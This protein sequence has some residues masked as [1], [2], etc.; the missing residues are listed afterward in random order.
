[1]AQVGWFM[2][3]TL[4][5]PHQVEFVAA[6]ARA[7]EAGIG[8]DVDA[9]R[10][11]TVPADDGR[12]LQVGLEVPGLTCDRRIL[13]VEYEPVGVE[14]LPSLNSFWTAG[15]APKTEL[16]DYDAPSGLAGEMWVSGVEA[17]PT[18]CAQWAVAWWSRQLRRPV[19]RQEWDEPKSAWRSDPAYRERQRVA[20]RWR[21]ED[22]DQSLDDRGTFRWWWLV[23]RP[24][25]RVVRERH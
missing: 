18:E 14:G 6:L 12:S 5:D 3:P 7:C 16:D 10:T 4:Q 23:R 11:S 22:P 17:T 13:A 20:A 19:I 8:A 24:P 21:L 2:G 1:M 25:T 15:L 9:A